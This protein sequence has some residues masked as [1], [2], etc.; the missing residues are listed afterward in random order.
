MNTESRLRLLR[1]VLAVKIV[2]TVVAWGLAAL[3]GPP[4]LFAFFGIPFPEDPTFHNIKLFIK[5]S[6][7]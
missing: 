3:V 7:Y 2:V 6:R 1:G 5:S 4:A